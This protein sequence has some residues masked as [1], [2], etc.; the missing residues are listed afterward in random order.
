MGYPVALPVEPQRAYEGVGR[1]T[2]L[3][4]RCTGA[5]FAGKTSQKQVFIQES[6]CSGLQWTVFQEEG[7]LL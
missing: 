1:T 5:G 6:C 4:P 7:K 3:D 2:D